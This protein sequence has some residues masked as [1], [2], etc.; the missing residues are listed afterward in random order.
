MLSQFLQTYAH[1][2]YRFSA[3]NCQLSF[4]LHVINIVLQFAGLY[5]ILHIANMVPQITSSYAICMLQI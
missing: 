2:L 5:V 4:H 3:F 1:I